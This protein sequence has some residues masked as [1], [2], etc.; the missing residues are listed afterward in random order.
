MSEIMPMIRTGDVVATDFTATEYDAAFPLQQSG[1][2][3]QFFTSHIIDGAGTKENGRVSYM[4]QDF[5]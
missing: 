4:P 1:V 2:I 5:V 3:A